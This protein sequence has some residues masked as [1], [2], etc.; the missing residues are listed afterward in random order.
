MNPVAMKLVLRIV[1]FALWL[2]K[3]RAMESSSLAGI[4]MLTQIA[5]AYFPEIGIILDTVGGGSAIGA[6]FKAEKGEANENSDPD[7]SIP[8]VE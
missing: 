8:R 4:A 6:V 2:A 1:A 3:S 7:G 5:K